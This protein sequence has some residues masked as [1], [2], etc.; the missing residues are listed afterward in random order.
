MRHR[1]LVRGGNFKTES[2]VV[3]AVTSVYEQ[4]GPQ[5]EFTKVPPPRI[6]RI[7]PFSIPGQIIESVHPCFFEMLDVSGSV[8]KR[9]KVNMFDSNVPIRP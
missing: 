8:S 9:G 3:C 5:M 7:I 2:E 4:V 6:D 1:L